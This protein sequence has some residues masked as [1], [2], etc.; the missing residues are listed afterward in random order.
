MVYTKNEEKKRVRNQGLEMTEWNATAIGRSL[1][2]R[3]GGELY[4][5]EPKALIKDHIPRVYP[6]W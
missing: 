3:T 6:T 1:H 5:S 4:E 2:K